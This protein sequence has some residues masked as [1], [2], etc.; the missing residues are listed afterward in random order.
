MQDQ[1]PNG[2]HSRTIG[3][4]HVYVPWWVS[5]DNAKRACGKQKS[6]NSEIIHALCLCS[7]IAMVFVL[8]RV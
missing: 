5:H 7:Q 2:V 6:H 3:Q 8:V 4:L 1:K